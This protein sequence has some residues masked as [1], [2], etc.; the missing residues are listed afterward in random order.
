[1]IIVISAFSFSLIRVKFAFS[2]SL[3]GTTSVYLKQIGV[4]LFFLA[5]PSEIRFFIPADR[6]DFCVSETD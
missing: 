5:D 4:R 1:M 6:N 3:I 2:S